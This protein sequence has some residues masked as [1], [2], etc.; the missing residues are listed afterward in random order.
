MLQLAQIVPKIKNYKLF[1]DNWFTSIPLLHEL[2]KVGIQCLGTVRP[3]CLPNISMPS[4][5]EMKKKGNYEERVTL[6][7]GVVVRAVKYYDKRPVRFATTCASVKSL[8]EKLKYDS[9]TEK[10]YHKIFYHLIDMTCESA[11][12]EYK[13]YCY[14][15]GVEKRS[16]ISFCIQNR[17]CRSIL[18]TGTGG[19]EDKRKAFHQLCRTRVCEKSKKGPVKPIPSAP[20][21]KDQIGHFHEFGKKGRCKMP[22][23]K[24]ITKIS[25]IKCKIVE[26]SPR[27]IK[28]MFARSGRSILYSMFWYNVTP[29]CKQKFIPSHKL[30][31]ISYKYCS[32]FL[33]TNTETS[34]V[35]D[36]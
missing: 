12:Q 23:C 9:M 30:A 3:N 14:I 16:Q 29:R 36:Y 20:V 26:C 11:W 17:N 32:P 10:F 27:T 31:C 15:L 22:G 1:C 13:Q 4:E 2:A 33:K 18:Q 8:I 7:S 24:G 5:K 35:D 19:A 34:T 25:C 21:R 28:K 6:V